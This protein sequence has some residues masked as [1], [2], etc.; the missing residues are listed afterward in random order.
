MRYV[1]CPLVKVMQ[2]QFNQAIVYSSLVSSLEAHWKLP[3]SWR[4][5]KVLS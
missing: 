4:P 1:S 5:N 3:S 2:Y